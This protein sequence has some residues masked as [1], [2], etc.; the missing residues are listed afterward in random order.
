[1]VISS[2]A[3]VP[4]PRQG[5]L[6]LLTLDPHDLVDD[7]LVVHGSHHLSN[8]LIIVKIPKFLFC[9][10]RSVSKLESRSADLKNDGRTDELLDST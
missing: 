8:S 6:L 4:Q 5:R 1:M 2:V 3:P 10:V 7:N 9:F